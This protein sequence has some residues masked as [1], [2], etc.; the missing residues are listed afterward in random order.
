MKSNKTILVVTS[1]FYPDSF[2]GSNKVVYE[3]GKRLAAS[4]HSVY[5]LTKKIK[6]TLPDYEI[7]E[8]MHIYRCSI[9]P[10][11]RGII[12]DLFFVIN[13][14]RVYRRLKHKITFDII[15]AHDLFAAVGIIIASKKQ[16][17]PIV[18]HFYSP[19]HQELVVENKEKTSNYFYKLILKVSS[20][21]IKILEEW[22]FLGKADR[23]VVLSNFS[24]EQLK[25]LYRRAAGIPN[26]SISVIAGGVDF[27][28]FCPSLDRVATRRKLNLPENKFLFLTVRRLVCRMG[29]EN[30]IMTIPEVIKVHRD[31]VLF[32]IGEG[33]LKPR[34]SKLIASLGLD[35]HVKLIGSV[36]EDIIPLYYQAA[37][38]FVIPTK[39]LE[40]FGLVTLEALACGT[41]VLGTPIG[42]TKEMLGKLDPGFLFDDVS[43]E[44]MARLMIKMCNNRNNLESLRSVCAE[45]ARMN[46][47]W[48]KS[49]RSLEEVF[50]SVTNEK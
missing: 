39:E 10:V 44:A 7:I 38:I 33:K 16:R 26:D 8:G 28:K 29:L 22:Y 1:F 42:N 18:S 11:S 9:P 15:Y 49:A 34:L 41:P 45:Y 37:D 5:I 4:G 47:S 3:I 2:G 6:R 25:M 46:Y 35:S 31:A 13:V 24:R 30:F 19:A 36:E 12:Q 48:D 32:I 43:T 17:I 27:N 40:G 50:D 21:V 14:G 20:S 23:I